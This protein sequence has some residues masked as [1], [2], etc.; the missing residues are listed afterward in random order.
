MLPCSGNGRDL[1]RSA[2]KVCPLIDEFELHCLTCTVGDVHD[3][4]DRSKTI[5]TPMEI[6]IKSNGCPEIP[7]INEKEKKYGA[8]VLQTLV[9]DYCT[10][11]IRRSPST[12]IRPHTINPD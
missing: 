5:K 3:P 9:R 4:Q 8:K 11:H 7:E 12:Y 1:P 10:A 2:S 6:P